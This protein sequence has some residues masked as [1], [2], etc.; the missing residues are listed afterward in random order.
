MLM[1]LP[2]SPPNNVVSKYPKEERTMPKLKTHSGAKKRFKLSKN[3]KVIRGHA[4]TSHLLNGH[5]KTPKSKRAMR[6]TTVTD[7]TNVAAIKRMLPYK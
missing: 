4:N 6:G 2:P 5:G 1:F 7:K 3:G